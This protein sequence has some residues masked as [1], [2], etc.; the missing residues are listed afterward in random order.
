MN[1]TK[2]S[3]ILKAIEDKKGEDIVS[4]DVEE[5]SPFFSNVI[6]ATI[7]NTRQGQAIA[8]EISKVLDNI[9]EPIKNIEG[10]K[11][12]SWI[13]IDAGDIIVHLFT[14]SERIRINLENLLEQ[15]L[16]E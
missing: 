6:I 12:S 5:R 16:G 2:L 14:P 1:Q 4:L 13:L 10:K 8:E 3:L 15:S 9:S 11:D 7:S